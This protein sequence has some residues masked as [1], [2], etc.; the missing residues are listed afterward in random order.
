MKIFDAFSLKGQNIEQI[1]FIFLITGLFFLPSSLLIAGIFLIPSAI[2]GS[3]FNK[4]NYFKDFYNLPFLICGI[5]I[6]INSLF[7]KFLIPNLYENDWNTNLTI[8][9]L[10]NWLPFFWLFWAFD[11]YVD[12]KFK[13]KLIAKTLIFGTFPVLISGFGQYFFNWTGPFEILNGLIIWYQKPIEYPAGLS[14]LFSNQNYAGSWLNLVWPFCISL[15]LEKTRTLLK[16][17]FSISFLISIGCAIFLT[18]SR[19]AWSG[20]LISLPLVIGYESLIWLLP[21]IVILFITIFYTISEFFTGEIQDLFR[22]IIPERMWKEFSKEGFENLDASRFEIMKSAI[23]ISFLRP[24]IGVGAAS[25]TAIYALETTFWKGHSHN[26]ILELAISYGYPVTI[27]FVSTILFILYSSGRTIFLNKM[28]FKE[29][30]FFDRAWWTALFFFSISQLADIQYFD[31]KISLVTWLL[32]SGLK[33]IID[34]NIKSKII[35]NK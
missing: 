4:K 20:L 27:I 8:A 9:G 3:F 35:I 17:T 16:K 19:N 34:E 15:V 7:Q 22:E 5:L 18:N 29:G 14:G 21:V 33:K 10:A 1:G 12:S 13:R 25:F 11:T 6:L 26:L 31:G 30:N 2:I 24:I 32:L 28:V 23:K